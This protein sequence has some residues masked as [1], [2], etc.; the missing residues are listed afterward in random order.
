MTRLLSILIIALLLNI[1]VAQGGEI[2]HHGVAGGG[3]S[4]S[5][6]KIPGGGLSPSRTGSGFLLPIAFENW[7]NP[8]WWFPTPYRLPLLPFTY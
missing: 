5:G 6:S 8:W 7:Q 4:G 1:F 2:G 3:G